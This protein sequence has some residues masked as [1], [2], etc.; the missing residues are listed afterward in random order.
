MYKIINCN[1]NDVILDPTCGSGTFLTNA[2]ANMLEE[3]DDHQE[4]MQIME[5]NIFGIENDD[6]NATLAGINMLLH[7]DGASNIYRDDCFDRLPKLKN[8]FNK[9]LMN[10]PFSQ[11]IPELKFVLESLNNCKEN[12]MCAA[13]L[14]LACAIGNKYKEERKI[15]LQKHSLIK[16]IT[17]PTDLF[18]PNAGVATCIMVFKAH[19]KHDG[20]IEQYDFTDDGYIIAKHVGRINKDH[21]KKIKLFYEQVPVIKNVT[22]QDN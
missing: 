22:Y 18:Q 20:K 1:K 15:L 9:I 6:F 8:Q 3:T 10:P 19:V 16:V 13:I 4:Q 5:N 17:L 2:M 12:G 11:K 14:P 21:D 7:G